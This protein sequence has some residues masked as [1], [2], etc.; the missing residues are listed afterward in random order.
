MV[1]INLLPQAKQDK[2]KD[3]KTKSLA[4]TLIVVINGG[5]IG[6]MVVMFLI[7]QA[8]HFAISRVQSGINDKQ[9]QI[10]QTKNI[11]DMV[12]LQRN[13]KV[14]PDLYKK[15]VAIS[16]F[17]DVLE[18]VAPNSVFVTALSAE[19]DGKLEVTGTAPDYHSVSTLADAMKEKGQFNNVTLSSANG[20]NG[21]V[22]YTITA[23]A[24][25]LS[26]QVTQ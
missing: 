4:I 1:S 16:R 17:F 20:A 8:Q 12:S 26:G 7:S 9:G 15:R 13:L 22:S 19:Q 25:L 23:S 6:A 14:L 10:V 21:S 18:E 5:L 3:I 2:Q 24:P 11:Q